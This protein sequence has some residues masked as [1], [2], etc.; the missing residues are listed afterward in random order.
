MI[1]NTILLNYPLGTK[2]ESIIKTLLFNIGLI[3]INKIKTIINTHLYSNYCL[4]L[5]TV[6]DCS[7]YKLSIKSFE[8][9]NI[10][11][12]YN[13]LYIIGID[14]TTKIV[15]EQNIRSEQDNLSEHNSEQ[16]SEK[17][18]YTPFNIIDQSDNKSNKITCTN[19]DIELIRNFSKKIK[20]HNM[21]GM[22][23]HINKIIREVL[24][25]RT[26]IIDKSI[27]KNM[28]K[29][30]GIILH[31]PPG[32]G[33]TTFAK[34]IGKILNCNQSNI[35]ILTSTEILNKYI[36]Q[37]EENARVL[38]EPAI[39]DYKKY[40]DNSPLHLIIIDEIDA[41]LG[42]R[43]NGTESNIKDSVVN[44]FLGLLDGINTTSNYIIIGITNLLTKIDKAILRPG[45]FGCHIYIGLPDN[46]QRK[47]IIEININKFNSNNMVFEDLDIEH[48]V[49]MTDNFSGADIENI[50]TQ[51]LN[52]YIYYKLDDSCN[53]KKILQ[54]DIDEIILDH[55]KK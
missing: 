23:I 3:D 7:E 35:H 4:T 33:K 17:D 46:E 1:T 55:I 18:E 31:G 27:L 10:A 2:K 36:G 48:L 42:C 30:N 54:S 38:F 26:N 16:N 34:N 49:K 41:I 51:A 24:I 19:L 15:I 29:S 40:G 9:L 13:D 52:K 25:S 37:S 39:S 44:Q 6:I 5:D 22:D 21:G 47:D 45:R 20:E 28:K 12:P 53:I 11:D 32:T 50:F 43:N 8:L 14:E